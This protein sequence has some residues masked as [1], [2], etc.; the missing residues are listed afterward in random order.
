MFDFRQS[1]DPDGDSFN[2]TITSDLES[3]PMVEN[4]S[5][6]YWYNDYMSAGNHVLTFTL[7]DET[8]LT[9][10]EVVSLMVVESDP[11]AVVYEPINNQFYEPGELIILDSMYVP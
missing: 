7:T 3:E 9:R 11:Q 5:I 8:G 10:D 6:D 1:Y 4:G 2:V